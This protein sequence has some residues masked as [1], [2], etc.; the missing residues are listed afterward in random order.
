LKQKLLLLSTLTKESQKV[1]QEPRVKFEKLMIPKRYY[2]TFGE[3][4]QV[5]IVSMMKPLPKERAVFQDE[6][7][8]REPEAVTRMAP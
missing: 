1:Q 7:K 3:I 6:Q 4:I 8:M 5:A 2:H